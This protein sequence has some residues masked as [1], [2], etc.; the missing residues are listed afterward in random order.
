MNHVRKSERGLKAREDRTTDDTK[1][2]E[3]ENRSGHRRRKAKNQCT[4]I[5]DEA[6]AKHLR[7]LEI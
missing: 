5:V 2:R 7:R 4:L 1:E 3:R 6:E